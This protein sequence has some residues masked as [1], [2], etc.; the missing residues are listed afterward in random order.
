MWWA[1]TGFSR[2]SKSW[3]V[4]LAATSCLHSAGHHESL[5]LKADKA[6][7]RPAERVKILR[8]G[9]PSAG[10]RSGLTQQGKPDVLEVDGIRLMSSQAGLALMPCVSKDS[11]SEA[12]GQELI[13]GAAGGMPSVR[14]GRSRRSLFRLRP[15]PRS[16]STRLSASKTLQRPARLC[17]AGAKKQEKRTN[18]KPRPSRTDRCGW[19]FVTAPAGAND[20]GARRTGRARA[21]R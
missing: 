21:T 5:T 16:F 18:C 9:A 10:A 15:G 13:C 7:F 14:T 3:E 1:C 11:Q 20:H 8:G 19:S 4:I 17:G 2:A 6:E 12:H